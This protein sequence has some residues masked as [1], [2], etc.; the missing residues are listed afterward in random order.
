MLHA[1]IYAAW[2][3]LV[4]AGVGALLGAYALTQPKAALASMGLSATSVLGLSEYR[5]FGG[6]LLASHALTVVTLLQ[7]PRSGPASRALWPRA[8]SEPPS[9]ASSPAC[10][11][12][13][14]R[15]GCSSRSMSFYASRLR[16]RCG[17][18][19]A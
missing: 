2:I 11:T 5:A 6:L 1:H 8:G 17:P 15:D 3:G 9:A 7:A 18:T 10:A 13:G 16:R 14:D 19:C 4:G 12:L